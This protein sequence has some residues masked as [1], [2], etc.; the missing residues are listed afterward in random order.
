L[1]RV[2]AVDLGTNSTRL[3]VADIENGRIV[4][5]ERLLTVTRLGHGVDRAGRLDPAAI[6]RVQATLARYRERA[7]TLAA[8]TVLATA[9]SAVR[10]AADGAEFLAG[11]ERRHGFR[12]RLLSGDEEAEYTFRGVTS[13]R[14]PEP[15]ILIVD[16]GGGS[17]ELTLGGPG[18]VEHA[19]SLAL[20]CVRM[21]ERFLADDPPTAGELRALRD[22]TAALVP[23]VFATGVRRLIGVAGTVTTLAAIDLGLDREIPA[24]VDGHRLRADV[25][26]RLLAE[27]AALPV[28]ER[29]GVRGLLPARAPTIVAGSAILAE[30]MHVLGQEE[31]VVSERDILHGTALAA[32]ALAADRT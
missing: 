11:V 27:L 6:E 22:A 1:T 21:Q 9:T 28:A 14:A 7:D 4:E 31:L 5:A 15:G 18:G 20:G 12:T 24:L 17:T 3:L 30:L 8:E 16:I 10:D 23:P 19:V 29:A 32:A 25:V 26:G 2:G 13:A